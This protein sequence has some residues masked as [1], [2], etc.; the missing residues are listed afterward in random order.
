MLGAWSWSDVI[1]FCFWWPKFTARVHGPGVVCCCFGFGGPSVL[2]AWSWSGVI[3]FCFWWP[4]FTMCM[5][6]ESRSGVHYTAKVAVN[7]LCTDCPCGS[8]SR[9]NEN[10]QTHS[11]HCPFYHSP[12][13]HSHQGSWPRSPE[14]ASHQWVVE[15]EKEGVMFPRS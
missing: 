7:L 8:T 6:L 5:V 14:V 12:G 2:C 4:K 9:P 1:M 15:G 10:I 3:M 11:C 13:H